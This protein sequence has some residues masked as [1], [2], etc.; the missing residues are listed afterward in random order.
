MKLIY[1]FT[2]ASVNSGS[3]QK[4]VIEQI[5]ALRSNGV[6]CKGLFFTT[7]EFDNNA[8]EC[9]EFISV[10]KVPKTYFRSAK[11]RI[12]YHQTVCNYFN[13]HKIE[14]DYIYVRYPGAG[15][16][17]AK[18]VNEW[19]HKIFFEHLT[20]ETLEIRLYGRENPFKWSLSSVLSRL[21]FLYWPLFNEW[22]YGK[23]IRNNAAFGIANSMDIANYENSKAGKNYVKLINGDAVNTGNYNVVDKPL[24][25]NQFNMV[26]LKGAVT[27]ADF[28]GLD[29]LFKG[30]AKYQGPIQLHLFL[31]GKNLEHEKQLIQSLGIQELVTAGDF[32]DKAEIDKLMPSIHLGIAALGVHRK[33]LKGT[34]TIKSREYC[35]R[36]IPFI[37]GHNDPDFSA[38]KVAEKFCKEYPANDSDINM[39]ELIEWYK[40]ISNNTNL[41]LEM[42]NFS[43]LNLDYNSKMKKLKEFLSTWK[44]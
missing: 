41:G 31:Y 40:N 20:S 44:N 14:T 12:A 38:V 5:Q 27:Q 36:G 26:F 2:S 11:Q 32:I 33:G 42:H 22:R 23:F 9:F 15:K 29:R 30:M 21:E 13:Q 17:I 1:V 10:P 19:G 24:F 3:V 25:K 18:W 39:N 37:Y 16:Y 4:K 6:E 34:T 8:T 35:A 28:N 7:D 43:K